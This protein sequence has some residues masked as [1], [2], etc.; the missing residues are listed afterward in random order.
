MPSRS[1]RQ[2]RASLLPLLASFPS[3][4]EHNLELCIQARKPNS[5]PGQRH[6]EVIK[7]EVPTLVS[8]RSPELIKPV[9]P[10]APASEILIPNLEGWV[11][12][13]SVFL[14]CSTRESDA[15]SPRPTLK[16]HQ[17]HCY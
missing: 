7:Q 8:G 17:Q 5:L 13:E 14:T 16:K 11:N 2:N 15:D 9:E 1:V 6:H 12:P 3:P 10:Q 4:A